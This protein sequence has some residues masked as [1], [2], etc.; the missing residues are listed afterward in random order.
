MFR[1]I[2][3]LYSL[4]KKKVKEKKK[5]IKYYKI[6]NKFPVKFYIVKTAVDKA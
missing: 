2:M 5:W 6:R 4:A 1:R 3:T